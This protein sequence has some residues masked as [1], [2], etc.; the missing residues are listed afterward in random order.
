M[1]GHVADL[2]SCPGGT[3]ESRLRFPPPA[4]AEGEVVGVDHPDV[5][6]SVTILLAPQTQNSLQTLGVTNSTRRFPLTRRVVEDV[7]VVALSITGAGG[8]VS[9]YSVVE[10]SDE[11]GVSISLCIMFFFNKFETFFLFESPRYHLSLVSKA[12]RAGKNGQL[13]MVSYQ[14]KGGGQYL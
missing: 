14:N 10:K 5:G 2:F 4:S 11:R 3:G 7:V 12:E 9:V 1:P 8:L 13:I 6:A